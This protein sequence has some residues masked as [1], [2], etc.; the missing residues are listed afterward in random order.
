MRSWSGWGW[1]ALALGWLAAGCQGLEPRLMEPPLVDALDAPL[2]EGTLGVRTLAEGRPGEE[3]GQRMINH[4]M[5][6]EPV[7]PESRY[8]QFHEGMWGN[9]SARSGRALTGV[10]ARYTG[11]GS[12]EWRPFPWVGTVV[13]ENRRS[14]EGVTDY[15]AALLDRRRVAERVVRLGSRDSLEGVDYVLEGRLEHFVGI[16]AEAEP[17]ADLHLHPGT[18]VLLAGQTSMT[19]SLL[20]TASGE[21]MWSGSFEGKDDLVTIDEPIAANMPTDFDR[22]YTVFSDHFDQWAV[23]AMQD[24]AERSLVRVS[25]QILE[26]METVLAPAEKEVP[27]PDVFTLPLPEEVSPP[28][29]PAEVEPKAPTAPGESV[30]G[31]DS[32]FGHKLQIPREALES[33]QPREDEEK[34]EKEG[35]DGKKEVP[36]DKKEEPPGNE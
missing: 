19:L 36:P 14:N 11:V 29:V 13:A 18:D 22:T 12:F 9:L 20:A 27:V 30:E 32:L 15:L 33:E 2:L 34:E 8:W 4:F 16:L 31:V 28:A 24:R 25:H 1:L 3:L 23:G 17:M 35:A 7:T 26:D 6:W 10:R 5:S 21:V